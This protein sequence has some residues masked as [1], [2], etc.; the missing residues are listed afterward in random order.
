MI[1]LVSV[2][3]L[4]C[5]ATYIVTAQ[6]IS[7]N[8]T[9]VGPKYS[10]GNITTGLCALVTSEAKCYACVHIHKLEIFYWAGT[11]K[12]FGKFIGNHQICLS[13]PVQYCTYIC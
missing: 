4:D 8:G 11:V 6:G 1:V 3:G 5:E 9:V 13:F 7:N 10:T 12:N 2:N